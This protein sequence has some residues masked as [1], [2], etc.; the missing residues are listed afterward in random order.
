MSLLNRCNTKHTY[1]HT[2]DEIIFLQNAHTA[3]QMFIIND[4]IKTLVLKMKIYR[5]TSK[6]CFN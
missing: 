3:N 2:H 5:H 6:L 4:D 1:I